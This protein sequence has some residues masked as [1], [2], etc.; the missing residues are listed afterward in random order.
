MTNVTK[1]DYSIK[2]RQLQVC[3]S[4]PPEYVERLKILSKDTHEPMAH[5]FREALRDLFKKYAQMLR[6]GK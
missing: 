5:F 4:L 6:K 1:K 2:G 3:V